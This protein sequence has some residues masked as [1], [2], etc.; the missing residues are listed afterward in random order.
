MVGLP[1]AADLDAASQP[2][3]VGHPR[4]L[5]APARAQAALVARGRA[6]A[7]QL[8]QALKGL[9]LPHVRGFRVLDGDPAACS[10]L[11]TCQRRGPMRKQVPCLNEALVARTKARKSLRMPVVAE[12]GGLLDMVRAPRATGSLARRRA[13]QPANAALADELLDG[14]VVLRPQQVG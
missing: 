5:L 6:H 8:H 12:N 3:G 1:R 13:V 2:R 9:E 11:R 14:V 4:G 7:R 10:Y